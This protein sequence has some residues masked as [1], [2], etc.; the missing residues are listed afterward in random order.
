MS[1]GESENYVVPRWP[2]G[3]FNLE[4]LDGDFTLGP[5]SADSWSASDDGSVTDWRTD[6]AHPINLRVRMQAGDLLYANDGDIGPMTYRIVPVLDDGVTSDPSQPAVAVGDVVSALASFGRGSLTHTVADLERSFAGQDAVGLE[7]ALEPK[8]VTGRTLEAGLIARDM[9]GRL[10]DIVHAVAITVALPLLLEPGEVIESVS[11]AA[12]NSPE[13]PFDLSTNRRIAEFKLSRWDG[14]DTARKLQL[15]KDL[16]HL[17]ADE[18]GRRAQLFVL[19]ERP[20]EF[21]NRS[22]SLIENLLK[23]FP[24]TLQLFKAHFGDPAISIAE[25]RSSGGAQVEMVDLRSILGRAIA[26]AP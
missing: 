10:N 17:A 23:R 1:D 15:A 24:T 25:F 11:L 9:F 21:V 3:P 5:C 18:S 16:V 19:D 14:H 6:G 13:R 2:K 7:A 12:G 22:R 20:L 26:D 8:G 4:A